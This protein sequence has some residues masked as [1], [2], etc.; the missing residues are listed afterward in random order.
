MQKTFIA[1]NKKLTADLAKAKEEFETANAEQIQAAIDA[2]IA[3]IPSPTEGAVA[4]AI[5]QKIAELAAERDA[6]IS[7]AV[8]DATSKLQADLVKAQEQIAAASSTASLGGTEGKEELAQTKAELEASK[9]SF[10]NELEQVK[11]QLGDEARSR[12]KEITDRLEAELEKVK[13]DAVAS[14]SVSTSTVDVDSIVQTRLAELDATRAAN[15]QKLIEEA[16]TAAVD[17]ERAKHEALLAASILKVETQA[18][19]KNQ[20][21]VKQ[22]NNFKAAKATPGQP[23]SKATPTVSSTATVTQASTSAA[24]AASPAALPIRP[25]PEIV[26]ANANTSA[27]RGRGRGV[28]NVR[29]RGAAPHRGGRGGGAPSI[30]LRGAAGGG[31]LGHLLSSAVKDNDKVA[32]PKRAREEDG[33][34]LPT[35]LAKRIKPGPNSEPQPSNAGGST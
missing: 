9:K 1:T 5:A 12:E 11:A 31:V 26:A 14:S 17:S 33:K 35:D 30:S 28:G 3:L 20:L 15:Q 4:E 8:S 29:G 32:G 2:R 18:A 25:A 16:V 6:A 10:E 24:P 23:A 27:T 22:L 7:S 19:L 34:E 21:L 13:K